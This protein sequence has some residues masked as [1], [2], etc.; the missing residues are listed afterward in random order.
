M[1]NG[2]VVIK[3]KYDNP[4]LAQNNVKCKYLIN[5]NISVSHCNHRN[6]RRV[7]ASFSGYAEG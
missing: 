6:Y 5:F 3:I 2:G 4:I 7:Q 1:N